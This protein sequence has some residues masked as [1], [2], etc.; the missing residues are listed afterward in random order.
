[1]GSTASQAPSNLKSRLEK[2]NLWADFCIHRDW[3]IEQGE[4][5][6]EAKERAVEAFLPR[7]EGWER[8]NP[9]KKDDEKAAAPFAA[10]QEP[11]ESDCCP[12]E[13]AS[14]SPSLPKAEVERRK[15]AKPQTSL[16]ATDEFMSRECDIVEEIRWVAKNLEIHESQLRKED[17]PSAEA[18]SML[19]SYRKNK[20][21]FW[22]EVFIRIIPSRAQL[23]NRDE[24]VPTSQPIQDTCD[25]LLRVRKRVEASCG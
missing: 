16:I 14:P 23:D 25:F 12:D 7:L 13:G 6:V 5:P 24:A 1:M 2:S 20:E 15:K 10:A 9:T 22:K 8:E 19:C 3:L 11:P 4:T 21:D 17:A 18:W